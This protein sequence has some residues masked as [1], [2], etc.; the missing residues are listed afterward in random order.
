MFNFKVI[1]N[2]TIVSVIKADV[3]YGSSALTN[4]T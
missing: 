1:K 3:Y 4:E 2:F